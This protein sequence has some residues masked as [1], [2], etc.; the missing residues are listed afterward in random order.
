MTK[1]PVTY[2]S[3][4]AAAI[5]GGGALNLFLFA[6]GA[7]TAYILTGWALSLFVSAW[8]GLGLYQ[9]REFTVVRR[10]AVII[11]AT[12]IASWAAQF[13]LTI[14]SVSAAIAVGGVYGMA[15]GFYLGLQLIRLLLSGGHPVFGVARTLID[16]A[17]RMKAPL[18]FLVAL[19][20]FVPVL[21]FAMDSDETLKYRVQTFL[22]WSMIVVSL[23]LSLMTVFLAVGTITSEI[24]R[25]QIFL[26]MTKPVGRLH[27]L[28]GKF[29]GIAMLN[30]LLVA[31][32]GGAIYVFTMML[33]QQPAR[34]AVDRRAVDEQILVARAGVSPIPPDQSNLAAQFNQR[35]TALRLADPSTYGNPGAPV[36]ILDPKIVD[37]IQQQILAEWYSIGPRN[38]NTFVFAGLEPAKRYDRYV[39][40]RIQPKAGR[41]T[42]DDRVFLNLRVNDRPFPVP[43][44]V[45]GTY[46][47]IDIPTELIEDGR[48]QATFSNPVRP[49]TGQEQPTLT[50]NQKDGIEV[51]YRVGSFEGNLLRSLGILWL[52]LAFLTMLGLA[53][54]TFL[55]FPV[56]CLAVLL[57][58][59]AAA[60]SGYVAESLDQYSS[61]PKDTLP[62]WDRIIG[63]PAMII[64]KVSEGEVWDGVKIIIRLVGTAFTAVIPEFGKYSTGDDLT[65][66]R[67]I[68][69]RLLGGAALWIGCV[70]TGVAGVIAYL[71]FRKRELARV[72]I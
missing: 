62:L 36:E 67:V 68:P 47:V 54:G 48:I 55:G 53:A 20:L 35:L 58:Y 61:F 19:M 57:V 50:F 40:L 18:V 6:Q 9:W 52:R 37:Q 1:N 64:E 13:C 65:H 49:D 70:S 21:P 39:Q 72:I 44:L 5:V 25:R 3:V 23:L 31:V 15:V 11:I 69:L 43:P 22:S 66:G 51:L 41:S 28:A 45:E 30:V 16:E 38:A 27:Y 32:C 33:S 34:S 42:E 60:G 29:L 8:V 4:L 71:I 24:G 59:F 10:L 12:V 26:T 63:V 7:V 17:I 2:F 46:H 14:G 56:A